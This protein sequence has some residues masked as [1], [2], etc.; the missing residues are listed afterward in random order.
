[1]CLCVVW[2]RFTC[3]ASAQW[4]F[5]LFLGNLMSNQK[6]IHSLKFRLSKRRNKIAVACCDFA[7]SCHSIK[8]P[9]RMDR[10]SIGNVEICMHKAERIQSR[11]TLKICI[12]TDSRFP[13]CKS[14]LC[15]YSLR[16]ISLIKNF[17]AFPRISMLNIILICLHENRAASFIL[18]NFRLIWRLFDRK[19][20]GH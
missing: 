8:K 5:Y 12:Q 20:P 17:S 14:T 16:Y 18:R 10:N 3:V 19:F 2:M 15:V 6:Y 11:L 1:M 7:I 4:Y 13:F 9:K